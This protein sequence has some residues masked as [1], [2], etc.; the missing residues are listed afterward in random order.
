VGRKREVS[1]A[2]GFSRIRGLSV[3]L[4]GGLWYFVV[5]A[6]LLEW[7]C[8]CVWMNRVCMREEVVVLDAV[9]ESRDSD[10]QN[11]QTNRVGEVNYRI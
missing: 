5:P 8:V 11:R 2:G 3:Y 10:E 1:R 9:G 7:W 6:Y 4:S